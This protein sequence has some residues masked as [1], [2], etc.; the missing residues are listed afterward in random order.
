MLNFAESVGLARYTNWSVNR[1]RECNPPG[2]NGVPVERVQQRDAEPVGL[3]RLHGGVREE[4]VGDVVA[5]TDAHADHVITDAHAHADD[6]VRFGW[7]LGGGLGLE[8]D[9]RFGRHGV[10]RRRHVDRE[11]VEL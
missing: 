7:L 2:N 4:H 11:P 5:D 6:F 9:L 8:P 1:D 10:V 3:H